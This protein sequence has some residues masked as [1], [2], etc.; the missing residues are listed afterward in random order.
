MLRPLEPMERLIRIRNLNI[1]TVMLVIAINLQGML[2][3]AAGVAFGSQ[4]PGMRTLCSLARSKI[5]PANCPGY[6]VTDP[7][8]KTGFEWDRKS[9][10]AYTLRKKFW[11]SHEKEP[12]RIDGYLV[13]LP[14]PYF[15]HSTI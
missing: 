3:K 14:T 7:K 15:Y 6:F 5:V 10:I 12:R 4:N 8:S 13:G 9:Y 2:K 11:Y 1:L